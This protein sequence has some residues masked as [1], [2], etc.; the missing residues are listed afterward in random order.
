MNNLGSTNLEVCNKCNFW[1]SCIGK[2]VDFSDI[3]H[4]IVTLLLFI[5]II[6]MV[7]IFVLFRCFCQG[8]SSWFRNWSSFTTSNSSSWT[9]LDSQW[10]KEFSK[11]CEWCVKL[12]WLWD[13]LDIW[14][15]R[16]F[17]SKKPTCECYRNERIF[18]CYNISLS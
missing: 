12:Y 2:Q 7:N 4:W 1:L 11:I 13:N 3:K 18:E 14:D 8:A 10:T 17:V 6:I 15:K 16:M 9:R 5:C